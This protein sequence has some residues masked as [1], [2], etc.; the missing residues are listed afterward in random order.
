MPAMPLDPGDPRQLD[1]F[2]LVG[3]LGEGGQGIVYLAEDTAGRHVAIKVLKTGA[4]EKARERLAREMAAAQRVAPFCTARVIEASVEG[5]RPYVVSEYVDGPSLLQR[6]RA[7]GP[8][9]EGELDRLVVGTATALTA[10]HGAGII[11]RDLKP[12]NVLLG[13]DGPRVVDFGIAR[14]I[15]AGTMTGL[16]GTPA[17]FAPEQ[18]AEQP[19]TPALD[20]F[21]WAATMVFAAT[22]K[23]PFGQDT[24]PAV[25]NRIAHHDPD[26]RGV[27]AELAAVLAEC[28]AKDPA[29]RPTARALLVRLVDPSAGVERHVSGPLAHAADQALATP[30]Q[31][32]QAGS[33]PPYSQPGPE[34]PYV[35]AEAGAL[36]YPQSGHKQPYGP[37]REGAPHYPQSGAGQSYPPTGEGAV[38]YPQSG[39]GQAYAAEVHSQGGV[40]RTYTSVDGGGATYPGAVVPGKRRRGGMVLAALGGGLAVALIAGVGLWIGLAKG[41]KGDKGPGKSADQVRTGSVTPS[42][43]G[44]AGAGK[45]GAAGLVVPADLAGT[46]SGTVVQKNNLLGGDLSSGVRLTL[47]AG[48]R[49]AVAA[50]SD[51]GCTE[52]RTLTSVSGATYVFG[53]AT[54]ND[55]INCTTM[56]TLTL[57]KSGSTLKYHWGTGPSGEVA[58]GV[59]SRS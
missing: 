10:I 50:Y 30:T 42:A 34:R 17:Y 7:G 36:P 20:L 55:S 9:H 32:T 27:P 3:R 26:L 21:A 51:W 12:A 18:L 54:S 13:P 33:P 52:T 43:S 48:G 35:P 16:V 19:P 39:P 24:I 6:V 59:L 4:D 56:G 58:D 37:T 2:R 11:H 40:E 23:A 31:P 1:R 47:T 15:D 41:D 25:L 49:N 46:W 45:S 57:A 29:Q 5:A 38:P 8:L 53:T 28:L 44:S 22:G 14:A